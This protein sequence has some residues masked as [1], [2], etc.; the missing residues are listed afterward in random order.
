MKKIL[1]VLSILFIISGCKKEEISYLDVEWTM[2]SELKPEI[3]FDRSKKNDS[4]GIFYVDESQV[5]F[6]TFTKYIEKLES[7]NYK[8][9]WK[10][11]DTDS[12]KKLKEEYEK[13]GEILKDK[14]V[15]YKMCDDK[16]CIYTQWV[17]KEEYNKLNSSKPV[18]YSFKLETEKIITEEKKDDTKN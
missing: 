1:L 17:N 12:L 5:S 10:Y 3:T 14:Y 9:D 18:S 6:Q 16:N 11:S 7:K 4:Y 13:D 15:N 8:V 2:D